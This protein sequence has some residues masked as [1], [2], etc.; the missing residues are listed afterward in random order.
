MAIPAL[1]DNIDDIPEQFRELYTEKDGKFE[2][3]GVTGFRTQG[4]VDRLQ[5]ALNKERKDLRE[6]R[7]KYSPLANRGEIPDIIAILDEHPDLKAAAEG[8]LDDA[9]INAIVENRMRVKLAPVERERDGFKTQL[10]EAQGI[11]EQYQRRDTARKISDAVRA[12]CVK[13]KVLP[14]AVDDAVM[15]AERIFEVTEDGRVLA[16][17]NVGVTPGIEPEAWLTDIQPRRQHWWGS[18]SGGGATGS[19]NGN[20][21]GNNPWSEKHWNVTEQGRAY[22]RDPARAQQMAEAAGSRIGATA[23]TPKA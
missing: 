6:L 9:K 10:A 13:A 3:T 19:R 15:N 21:Q 14:D 8:K 16:R 20:M 17:D 23:P 5:G 12:A 2:L 18:S 1:A 11:I 22:A 7:A 4:D